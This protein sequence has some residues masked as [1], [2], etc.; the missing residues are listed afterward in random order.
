MK[1]PGH[2]GP[3]GFRSAIATAARLGC[4]N[5]AHAH[6][7]PRSGIGAFPLGPQPLAVL[8]HLAAVGGAA[9]F[10]GAVSDSGS[11][12]LASASMDSV[13]AGYMSWYGGRRTSCFSREIRLQAEI[14][15]QAR[16]RCWPAPPRFTWP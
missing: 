6:P 4:P 7:V 14:K 11:P 15:A 10:L 13:S 9:R 3:S 2:L 1:G 16:N 12:G 8:R 5:Q